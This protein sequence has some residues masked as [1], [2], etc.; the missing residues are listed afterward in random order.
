MNQLY[1]SVLEIVSF[2]IMIAHFT[3]AI[4]ILWGGWTAL[5]G[6]GGLGQSSDGVS[7]LRASLIRLLRPMMIG[8]FGVICLLAVTYIEHTP[9]TQYIQTIAPLS[10]LIWVLWI[11]FTA[12]EIRPGEMFEALVPLSSSHV[13]PDRE[14]LAF[15]RSVNV[16]GLGPRALTQ[17]ALIAIHDALERSGQ[18]LS[19]RFTAD[20]V[21][22]LIRDAIR[23]LHEASQRFPLGQQLT[24]SDWLFEGE[25]LT[26][27]WGVGLKR[28]TFGRALINPLTLLDHK[29]IWRWSKGQPA[30]VFQRELT[31]WLHHGLYLLVANQLAEQAHLKTKSSSSSK[32]KAEQ[33]GTP[34]LWQM[35]SRKVLVPIWLYWILCS[36]AISFTHGW[37]GVTVGGVIGIVLWLTARRATLISRWR[38]E[39]SSLGTIKRPHRLS[40]DNLTQT[41]LNQ[42]DQAAKRFQDQAASAPLSSALKFLHEGGMNIALTYR[43][44]DTPDLP[45][46]LLNATVV[47]A[48]HTM[49][50]TLTDLI[51]WY[52]DGG[53][54]PTVVKLL[55]LFNF[56]GDHF[57]QKLISAAQAWANGEEEEGKSIE[58]RARQGDLWLT[59]QI[60]G[61]NFIGRSAAQFALDQVN[62]I[63]ITWM[64]NEL[65]KRTLPL[66]Q[67]AVDLE[68]Q[69][70]AHRT[71]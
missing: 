30:V 49:D 69:S 54:I 22:I 71:V 40:E 27:I 10:T 9:L 35:M 34:H 25:R 39:L 61:M 26:S 14:R 46:A 68:E 19:E 50:L 51:V 42:V 31:A 57:D 12:H 29:G 45:E 11:H 13:N 28:I 48:L 24:L 21:A 1:T 18:T 44:E 56:Q 20:E 60:A 67:G 4:W 8:Y 43:R 6:L 70:L 41:A 58:E 36:T 38:T 47:D 59:T 7:L 65:V 53:L 64:R 23:E 63:L 2:L 3:G 52:Q 33:K 17:T 55:T 37:K 66:Y 15:E 32:Q 16:N 62:T 5:G